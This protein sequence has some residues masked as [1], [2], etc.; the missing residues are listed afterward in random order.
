MIKIWTR[1]EVFEIKSN[2][3]ST[4]LYQSGAYRGKIIFSRNLEVGQFGHFECVIEKGGKGST[5]LTTG[6]IKKITEE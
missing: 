2:G 4:V 3:K 6:V 5:F 1:N